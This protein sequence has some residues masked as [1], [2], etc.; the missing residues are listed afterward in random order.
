MKKKNQ[1]NE[2]K[3]K[4]SCFDY[5]IPYFCIQKHKK[6]NFLPVVY[7]IIKK[8]LSIEEILPNMER[9]SRYYKEEKSNLK[10]MNN[11]F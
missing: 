9:L 2:N 3:F 1:E 11:F 4:I 6:N 5:I 7:N 8:Y 10:F